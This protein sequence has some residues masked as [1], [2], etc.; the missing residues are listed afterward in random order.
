MPWGSRTAVVSQGTPLLCSAAESTVRPPPAVERHPAQDSTDI[1]G[2]GAGIAP[3]ER[4]EESVPASEALRFPQ[5]LAGFFRTLQL[6]GSGRVCIRMKHGWASSLKI[7][8]QEDPGVYV[9]T[10]SS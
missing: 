3:L 2:S 1:T 5:A 9:R 10:S 4:K 8:Q 7:C 6:L